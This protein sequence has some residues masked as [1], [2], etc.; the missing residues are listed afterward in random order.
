MAA[1]FTSA[2]KY[3][4]IKLLTF[5]FAWRYSPSKK[6]PVNLFTW[7][8]KFS[9]KSNIKDSKFQP[10]HNIRKWSHILLQ[11]YRRYYWIVVFVT[12]FVHWMLKGLS[13]SDPLLDKFNICVTDFCACK[14]VLHA[15]SCTQNYVC[16][17]QWWWALIYFV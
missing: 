17:K 5:T 3:K 7:F 4:L 10:W 14:M 13:Q 2:H 8:W 16:I 12:I 9:M 1:R 11:S 15:Y 6:H